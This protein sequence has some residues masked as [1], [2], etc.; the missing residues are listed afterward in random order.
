MT[1]YDYDAIV[2]HS[3]DTGQMGIPV[4]NSVNKAINFAAEANKK[5]FRI[6]IEE[7]VYHE[8]LSI[9]VPGISLIG[10]KGKET[11]IVF[12]LAAGSV[13]GNNDLS[14]TWFCATVIVS[15]AGFSAQNIRFENS[16]DY[17]ANALKPD[18]GPEKIFDTQAVAL[19][20]CGDNDRASFYDCSFVGY[21]DTL[22]I[23]SGRHYFENCRI[24]GHI[25]FI[26]GAGQA[27]FNKCDI[28]SRPRPGEFPSGYLTA[29]STDISKP[30]GFLFDDCRLLKEKGV[31]A[32]SVC[33]GRPW[34]PRGKL[35]CSGSAV[36]FKCFMDDHIG[37]KGYDRISSITKEGRKLWFEI[38][39]DSR[40]FEFES[41]GP[42]AIINSGRPQL[43]L[44]SLHWH[45]SENIFNGWVPLKFQD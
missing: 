30:Y 22:F 36:F 1:A 9:N 12:N 35:S 44:E 7:G 37:A 38:K 21:Q 33:L 4:Y 31:D 19:M 42:G 2:S 15:A 18:G 27:V 10:E 41:Y 28:I 14:G 43:P 8:R 45:T 20:T 5:N 25:D 16:F 3:K 29:P 34:H 13:K 23:D 39:P 6:F 11:V 17:P 26:F 24:S 32:G 40:F